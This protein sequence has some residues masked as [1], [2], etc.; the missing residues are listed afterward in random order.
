MLGRGHSNGGHC[1]LCSLQPAC[2]GFGRSAIYMAPVKEIAATTW[3]TLIVN[4]PVLIITAF[5]FTELPVSSASIKNANLVRLGKMEHQNPIAV[6]AQTAHMGI[7][8]K[9][10]AIT[11]VL[12][13]LRARI[14]RL[15]PA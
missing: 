3:Q 13:V 11:P 9:K 7:T 15:H 5:S 14:L 6:R 10:L 4:S 8:K 2:R 12:N 1:N